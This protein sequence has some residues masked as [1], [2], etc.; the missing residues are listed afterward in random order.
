MLSCTLSV[1]PQ[2]APAQPVPLQMSLR[3]THTAPVALLVWGTPFE[4][5][6]TAS[7]VQLH[8][9]GKPL[10]YRGPTFKRGEPDRD[11]YLVLKAGET[12]TASLDLAQVFELKQPGPYQ[13]KPQ[14]VLHDVVVGESAALPRPREQHQRRE[15]ACPAVEFA[16][17]N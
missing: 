11:Q 13:V 12:R 16:I 9:Q 2:A 14:V 4:G 3:N 6:W 1:A 10:P 15:L 7:F 8:H 17:S 5:R